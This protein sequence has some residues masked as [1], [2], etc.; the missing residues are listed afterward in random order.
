MMP[1]S[2]MIAPHQ[3]R[4]QLQGISGSQLVNAEDTL[5]GITNGLGG[6]DLG[7]TLPQVS[8]PLSGLPQ[9]FPSQVFFANQP[10]QR[11]DRFDG[12]RPP[13]NLTAVKSSRLV[14]LGALWLMAAERNNTACI[15]KCRKSNSWSSLLFSAH[16]DPD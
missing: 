2:A 9:S 4:R 8:E 12:S 5:R 14:S 15:P 13:N 7:P 16:L 11:T 10:M 6:L 3:R 1:A